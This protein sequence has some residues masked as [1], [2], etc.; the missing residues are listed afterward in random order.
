MKVYVLL[1]MMLFCNCVFAAVV[2]WSGASVYNNW[3]DRPG[4]IENYDIYANFYRDDG[5]YNTWLFSYIF[6]HKNDEGLFLKHQDFSA[7]SMEPTYNWWVLAQYGEIVGGETFDSYTHVEDTSDYSFYDGGT[8]VDSPDDFYLVFKASEVLHSSEG[9]MEGQT[10]YGW[11]HVSIDENLHMTLLDQNVNLS[12]GA[13]TVGVSPTPEPTMKSLLLVGLA[14][15]LL[16]RREKP[17]A[18]VR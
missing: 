9:Y 12:G 13:V 16:L 6:A 4:E 17:C 18:A 15:I 11:L 10:W 2:S 1:S 3:S 14:G 8:L 7:E 5:K